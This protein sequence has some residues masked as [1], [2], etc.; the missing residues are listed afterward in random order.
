MGKILLIDDDAAFT[1]VLSDYIH[2]YFPLLKVEICNNPLHGLALIKKGGWD[3]LLIDMEMP[4]MDGFKLFRYATGAGMDK[5][6]IVI[7]SARETE[8]L[9]QFFPL[10]S[11]LAVLNKFEAKQKEV[12][13]MIFSSLQR[14]AAV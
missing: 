1:R 6:R 2:D 13:Q 8:Y 4:S 11:C 3:L 14:K 10:G 7:L 12:L 9:R 5:N